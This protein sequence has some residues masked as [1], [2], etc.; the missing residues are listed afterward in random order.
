M[1]IDSITINFSD[2]GRFI[3]DNSDPNDYNFECPI[4]SDQ[5]E[6]FNEKRLYKFTRKLEEFQKENG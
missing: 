5:A 2:G 3:I 1:N 6:E 4:P